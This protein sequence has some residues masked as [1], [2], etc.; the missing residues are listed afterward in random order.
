MLAGADNWLI[1]VQPMAS[2]SKSTGLKK[3][4]HTGL[5]RLLSCLDNE[6]EPLRRTVVKVSKGPVGS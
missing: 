6:T 1:S 5:R 2:E 3:E 4:D